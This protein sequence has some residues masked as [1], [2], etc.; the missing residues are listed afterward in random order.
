MSPTGD[1]LV[2]FIFLGE[3]F[4]TAARQISLARSEHAA[5]LDR[6]AS[7]SVTHAET[8]DRAGE[9]Q[10]FGLTLS[11]LSYRGCDF[12]ET[13]L[14]LECCREFRLDELFL[15]FASACHLWMGQN[16]NTSGCDAE[17]ARPRPRI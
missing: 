5:C 9:L 7:H 6:V 15:C 3:A 16:I 17:Q 1:L 8:R 13:Q 12:V 10:I 11:Q 14:S 4:S 2:A